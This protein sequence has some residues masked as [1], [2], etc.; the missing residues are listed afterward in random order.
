MMHW[1]RIDAQGWLHPTC[2]IHGILYNDTMTPEITIQEFDSFLVR[3]ELTFRGVVIGA[4]ALALL[5]VISRE[6]RDCDILDPEIPPA[7]KDAARDF[8]LG[9]RKSGQILSEKWLN[10]GPESLKK[11]LPSGWIKRC[12]P[13]F[14]GKALTL[15]TLGRSDFLK[16]KLF[17]FCDRQQDLED[18]I[19]LTPTHTELAEAIE[20]VTRQDTNPAWPK[21]V[22]DSFQ[23][24]RKRLGYGI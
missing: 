11:N 1:K 17:A 7:L 22:K 9:K 24:L 19:A 10:N 16:T 4:T 20:W 12:V 18:C 23:M 8:A 13:L 21:H 6:T 5:G 2:H 3:K 15:L 14:S